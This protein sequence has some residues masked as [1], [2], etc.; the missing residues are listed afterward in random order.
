M[1]TSCCECIADNAHCSQQPVPAVDVPGPA[2]CAPVPVQQGPQIAQLLVSICA[3]HAAL[4]PHH[5]PEPILWPAPG[6]PVTISFFFLAACRHLTGAALSAWLDH[7]IS[8]KPRQ[9]LVKGSVMLV[10]GRGQLTFMTFA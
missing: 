4:L 5:Q 1:L 9:S 10:V 3:V 2:A 7:V 6:I 8:R